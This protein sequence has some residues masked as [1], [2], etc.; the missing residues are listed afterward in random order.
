MAEFDVFKDWYVLAGDKTLSR[1]MSKEKIDDVADYQKGIIETSLRFCTNFRNALDI[2]ANYGT[3]SFQLSKHF[4]K[5]HAFEIVPEVREA[6]VKNRKKHNLKNVEIYDF[7]LGE[8]D[9]LVDIVFDPNSTFSTHVDPNTQQG[10]ILVKKLDGLDLKDLDFIKIDAEG[11]ESQIVNG[12]FE[13]IKKYKPVILYENKNHG[14]RY[15]R[16]KNVVLDKLKPY[17]YERLA[18]VG[19]KNALIGIKK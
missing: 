7:G 16:D 17:G 4:K 13:L 8:S 19:S 14:L 2:G 1:A 9:H 3:M 11:F 15:G 6:F 10:T 5:V 18:D 12:G